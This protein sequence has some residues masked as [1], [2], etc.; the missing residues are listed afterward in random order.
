[1]VASNDDFNENK[2][3]LKKNYVKIT[4]IHS[5]VFILVFLGQNCLF[6]I[7]ENF[8][9]QT[10]IRLDRKGLIIMILN[11]NRESSYLCSVNIP[12]T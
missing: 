8:K 11:K 5:L 12:K 7:P 1:M 10:K 2:T 9:K 4:Y 6:K 3:K